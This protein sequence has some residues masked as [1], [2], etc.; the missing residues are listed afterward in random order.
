[1]CVCSLPLAG[2]RHESDCWGECITEI[3]SQ[4]SFK[5]LAWMPGHIASSIVYLPD[6][7]HKKHQ[8][9]LCHD[10]RVT[11]F[12]HFPW[13]PAGEGVLQCVKLSCI[14]PPAMEHTSVWSPQPAGNSQNCPNSL[15]LS[16]RPHLSQL[17][18]H[19]C[20]DLCWSG[21]SLQITA[22][23]PHITSYNWE[24][25]VFRVPCCSHLP[26]LMIILKFHFLCWP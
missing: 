15:I 21:R 4:T 13:K 11:L 1:M 6:Q 16:D 22:A 7:W 3:E 2:C 26:C 17:Q 9:M 8:R 19:M 25:S 24:R 5:G 10:H 12:Q 23:T 14:S 20:C 18:Q